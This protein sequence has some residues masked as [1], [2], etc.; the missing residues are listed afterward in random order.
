M[1]LVRAVS[2]MNIQFVEN[3]DTTQRIQRVT[4]TAQIKR[5][6]EAASP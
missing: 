3:S 2:S 6:D 5:V 4:R 1:N